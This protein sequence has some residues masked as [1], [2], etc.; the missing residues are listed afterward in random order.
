LRIKNIWK[1][2]LKKL[3]KISKSDKKQSAKL[4][5]VLKINRLTGIIKM[6][7]RRSQAPFEF[8]QAHFKILAF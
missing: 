3:R 1:K 4:D 5:L 8:L 7:E 6:R 2:G